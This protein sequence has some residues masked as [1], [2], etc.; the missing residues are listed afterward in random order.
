MPEESGGERTLPASPLKKQRARERGNVPKSQD[1]VAAGSMLFSL[2]AL[3]FLGP[4]MLTGLVGTMRYYL[5]RAM[6]LEIS[7]VTAPHAATMM[8]LHFGRIVAPVLA[9]LLAAGLAVNF[10]QVGFLFAPDVISPKFERLNPISGFRK[11]F[12]VRSFVEL[13]KSILKLT[14]ISYVVYATFR[15]RWENLFLLSYMTPIGVV[16]A[17]AELTL[18]VWF[19]IILVM[20]AIGILDYCFQRWQYEQDLRMTTQEARE[21]LK[22]LEGDPRIRQRVRQIQRQIAMQ[23]MMAEVPKADVVIT[24][25]TT[26]AVALRYAADSMDAPTVTAKGARLLADRIR[27]IAV[28]NDVPIIEKP[29]LAR[30]LYRTVEV[31]HAI[32]ESLYRT[33][34]E[35]LSFVYE[36]DRRE[37][38]RQE[39]S[40]FL[41]SATRL[42]VNET[43]TTAPGRRRFARLG[44]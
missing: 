39:R 33:V 40:G 5:M 16:F 31:S 32:P 3:W 12:S 19:R 22:E 25:P 30:T 13:I 8:T 35:V 37:E 20:V 28:E 9:L 18:A 38:K 17:V 34:A 11:F 23:R 4:N 2:I 15:G 1:L 26:Y 21:E 44:A 6:D 43:Q 41:S 29:E 7:P 36:I 42:E 14:I 10:M 27:H 24:N